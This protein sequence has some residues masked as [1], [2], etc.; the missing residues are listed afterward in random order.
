MVAGFETRNTSNVIQVDST[1]RNFLLIKSGQFTYNGNNPA[2]L[3]TRWVAEQPKGQTAASLMVLKPS[4]PNKWIRPSTG[5]YQGS[6]KLCNFAYERLGS[7]V[8]GTFQYYIFDLVSPSLADRLGLQAFDAQ[9]NLTYNALDYPLRI[10]YASHQPPV[11]G[12]VAPHPN[13]AFGCLSGGKDVNNDDIDVECYYTYMCYSGNTVLTQSRYDEYG[14]PEG[15]GVGN[16]GD[17][18]STLL[19]A[20]VS[21]IPLN[22]SRQ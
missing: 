22:W 4:V 3:A 11:S 21:N 13:F 15:A 17:P 10:L 14:D 18:A 19:V 12:Y 9:G 8:T 16:W 20:D 5:G 2:D 7:G 6:T 1:N